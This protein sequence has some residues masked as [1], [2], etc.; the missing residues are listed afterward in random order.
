LKAR[1]RE[2]KSRLYLLSTWR[3]SSSPVPGR[4]GAWL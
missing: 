1:G 3:E 2:R 4:T